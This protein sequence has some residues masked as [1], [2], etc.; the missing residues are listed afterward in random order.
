MFVDIDVDRNTIIDLVYN[1]TNGN[2]STHFID[3]DWGSF[4]IRYN[5]EF[6]RSKIANG[7]ET[8][9]LYYRYIIDV[10]RCEHSRDMEVYVNGLRGVIQALKRLGA[11]VVA[12]CDFE[13]QLRTNEVNHGI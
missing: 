3:C 11:K 1:F 13:D 10:E 8:G 12:A 5:D 7:G 2:K 6:S 4:D 9:F